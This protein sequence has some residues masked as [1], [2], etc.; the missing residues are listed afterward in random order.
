MKNRIIPTI[1]SHNKKE[2]LERLLK[3]RNVSPELQIDFM[4]GKFVE[5]KSIRVS[6]V[7]DL[8]KFRKKRF[9]AHLMCKNPEKYL[10]QLAKKGFKKIIFHDEAFHTRSA[11]LDFIKKSKKKKFELKMVGQISEREALEE[12]KDLTPPIPGL[13]VGQSPKV[14]NVSNR[15]WKNIQ[16]LI[17]SHNTNDWKQAIMEADI[18]LDEMLDKM[19]YH[20][21]TIGDKLKQIEPSDFITLNQAW[22]AHKI[23]NQVAHTGS[24]V[25][26]REEAERTIKLYEEVFREFYFI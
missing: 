7:P 12:I 8:K 19:G 24:Y 18:I 17:N 10:E 22:E 21:E 9:E 23:R 4:D 15:R 1:F 3:L 14:Q 11:I 2:F 20:G 13:P 5:S 16:M 6:D 26:S 25:L